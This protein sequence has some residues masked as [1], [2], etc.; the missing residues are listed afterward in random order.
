MI[1]AR[2]PSE[3]DREEAERKRHRPDRSRARHAPA[4]SAPGGGAFRRAGSCPRGPRGRRRSPAARGRSGGRAPARRARPAAVARA[5]APGRAGRRAPRP[6]LRS[7][8]SA[9]RRSAAA[10]SSPL[11]S[12]RRSPSA[13]R[14]RA[15]QSMPVEDRLAH[16]VRSYARA[17]Q[18]RTGPPRSSRRRDSRR[19]AAPADR[20]W[21]RSGAGSSSDLTS[22]RGVGGRRGDRIAV[23]R[24][25]AAGMPELPEVEA[26]RRLLDPE[27]D[28]KPVAQ[29]G[30][31]HIA[32]LKT[33]DPP[34]AA[35]DGRAVRGRAPAG[36]AA[37][38]PDRGRRARR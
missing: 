2:S 37:A 24:R 27:V 1:R 16:P 35:L 25:Y 22:H 18:L 28:A 26:W 10:S 21:S 12:A 15:L 33:F 36:K 38:L 7:A 6:P 9:R 32:T 8:A 17:R 30:P 34:L 11:R 23:A 14:Q 20:D 13:R 4:R 19:A 3:H 5:A 31:A 29:A